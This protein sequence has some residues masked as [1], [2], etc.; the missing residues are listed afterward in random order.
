MRKRNLTQLII[1]SICIISTAGSLGACSLLDRFTTTTA[2][3][4]ESAVDSDYTLAICGAATIEGDSLIIDNQN[5]ESSLGDI[6]IPLDDNTP[7]LLDASNGLPVERASIT[8]G[9]YVYAYITEAMTMS[10]PPMTN[11]RIVFCNIAADAKVPDYVIVKKIKIKGDNMTIT[12]TNNKEYKLDKKN[13]T[14]QPY[15]TRNIVT[16]DDIKLYSSMI[17]WTDNDNNARKAVLFE[18]GYFE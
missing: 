17:I 2:S 16:A 6:I 14:L 9:S 3:L 11:A 5:E 18:E 12:G 7:L 10:L 13:V 1:T 15:L 4:D 8:D